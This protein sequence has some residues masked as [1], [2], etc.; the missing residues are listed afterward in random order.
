MEPGLAKGKGKLEERLAELRDLKLALL[1]VVSIALTPSRPAS[2]AVEAAPV[3]AG[4]VLSKA[5]EARGGRDA[6]NS[7]RSF[8]ARGTVFFQTRTG[9]WWDAA[10]ITNV[11]PLQV[12]AMRPDRFRFK[13]D[14]QG[15]QGASSVFVPPRYYDHGFDGRIAWEAPSERAAQILPGIFGAERREEGQFFAWCAEPTNHLS[16]INLGIT[17]FKGQ[18]CYELKLVRRSGTAETHYYNATNWLLAGLSRSSVFG[19]SRERLTFSEYR[20]FGG[21]KFPMQTDFEAEDE[22]DWGELRAV[23]RLDSLAVNGIEA[24]CF[25]M[26]ESKR[27]LETGAD[28]PRTGVMAAEVK[29]MLRDW[30]EEDKVAQ[31]VVV[32]LLD[33]RGSWVCGYGTVAGR[34][35]TRPEAINGKTLFGIASISKV[36]TRLL[37]LDMVQ[38]GEMKLDDPAQQYLPAAVRLPRRNGKEITL[39]HLATHTSGLPRYF[40]G[41]EQE[42][43]SQLS[44][45]QPERDPGE[46]YAYSNIGMGLLGKAIEHKA[47]KPYRQLVAQRICRPLGLKRTTVMSFDFPGV[48]GIKTCA[49]DLAKFSAAC[50]D[51]GPAPP[52][53]SALMQHLY[54]T[55]GGVGGNGRM[56]LVVDPVRRRALVTLAVSTNP[57]YPLAFARLN[58]LVLNP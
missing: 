7:V 53:L 15:T 50:L 9:P 18:R 51:L 6:F 56:Y 47:G 52:V 16:A 31:A 38:R 3:T 2:G 41:S 20:E 1:V 45:C 5:I 43:Y 42:V 35:A 55:H 17:E 25:R 39:L 34:S 44:A 4:E 46:V 54:A 14:L 19:P 11:W 28:V 40:S 26:P 24:S 12:Q 22:R 29:A 48:D 8:Q 57:N 33:E 58:R 21:L 23:E 13:V 27:P 30:I 37:L 36:F 49:E 10:V 32:S